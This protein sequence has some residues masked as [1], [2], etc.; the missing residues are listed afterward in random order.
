M[1]IKRIISGVLSLALSITL[2]VTVNAEEL[3]FTDVPMD[4]WYYND[5]KNAVSM[6]LVN[7]KT[8]TTYCPDDNLTYAETFKLAACMHQLATKGTVTLKNGDPWY[9]EYMEYCYFNS[10][11]GPDTPINFDS[12]D[13]NTKISRSGYMSIF[14]NALP[15]DMLPVIN[16]VPDGA[17]PDVPMSAIYSGGV[18]RLY[19]A[20]ILQGSDAEHN[21]K[22]YD[23][24]KRSEVAAILTR[25]MD[26]TK[27]VR[28]DMGTP[29]STEP[30]TLTE[31]PKFQSTGS[32]GIYS[33]T[34]K[35]KG[36]KAPYNYTWQVMED[37]W[38]DISVLIAEKPS[39]A[40]LLTDYS[41]DTITADF[42]ES[43][44]GALLFRCKVVDSLG[45]TVITDSVPLVIKKAE[46]KEEVKEEEVKEEAP[47]KSIIKVT[48]S[49]TQFTHKTGTI[50]KVGVQAEGGTR[51]YTYRWQRLTDGEWKN[52]SSGSILPDGT[53]D[54]SFEL[55]DSS[56]KTPGEEFII[57]CVVT[58]KDRNVGESEAVTITTAGFFLEKELPDFTD[59]CVGKDVTLSVKVTGGK[60]PYTYKWYFGE[61]VIPT[62][63][64]TASPKFGNTP[65]VTFTMS[66]DY[67]PKSDNML[68]SFKCEITDADGNMLLTSTGV[69]DATPK[70]M[71]L[72]IITQPVRK[73][74][75]RYGGY[76]EFDIDIYGGKQPYSYEWFYE[77][78]YKNNVSEISLNTLP[79]TEVSRF[80]SEISIKLNESATLLG[81]EIYCVV[82]DAA[83]TTVKSEKIAVCPDFLMVK[84]ESKNEIEGVGTEYVGTVISGEVTAGD[85]IGFSGFFD[86]K[87]EYISFTVERVTMFGKNLDKAASGDRVGLRASKIKTYES[88][89]KM[90]E[91]IGESEYKTQN[92]AFEA[93]STALEVTVSNDI[94]STTPGNRVLLTAYVN[95]GSETY[96]KLEWFKEVDGEWVY[97]ERDTS[98][99]WKEK[100][101]LMQYAY[102]GEKE[103]TSFKAKCI[104]TDSYGNT[105]ES[106]IVTLVT[107]D[108]GFET[109]LEAE[110]DVTVGETVTFSVKPKGG[111][112][113]Y[114]YKW[115]IHSQKNNNSVSSFEY[116]ENNAKCTGH[117][118][119]TV[120]FD[121]L[122]RYVTTKGDEG[123]K[124]TLA[125]QVTDATGAYATATTVLK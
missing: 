14:A 124:I 41:K 19:R 53:F 101:Y 50:T 23:N 17:I 37:A 66:G 86:G 80:K 103:P 28:F 115:Y 60:E 36:G 68:T 119:D 106:N 111:T 4:A 49:G 5:V 43:E 42:S 100:G 65:E 54:P 114:T 117:D 6:G 72:S 85:K 122:A 51:P 88:Q 90:K 44:S 93:K 82:T 76:L 47:E 87:H 67:L 84:L 39:I 102:Y 40:T 22:P 3:K 8:E 98:G 99:I 21:C 1:K 75:P 57:K 123:Y 11:F 77:S 59:M 116:L 112:A 113:P 62:K 118:T 97:I 7:G 73:T 24:I 94:Y 30:L 121:V 35:V 92:L 95:G 104:I 2:L 109:A 64:Y 45:N 38:F 25:M 105:A 120:T 96:K 32:D 27:R 20:G 83:G 74:T 18:Y 89:E 125:C 31:Q 81:K 58:D 46:N 34:V 26:K 70:D 10:M 55:T 110:T 29:E 52:H 9:A 56:I 91:V 12:L 78:R 61:F 15:L 63:S 69:K 107:S 16:Y 108:I 79:Q 48:V 33:A 71:P 13:V